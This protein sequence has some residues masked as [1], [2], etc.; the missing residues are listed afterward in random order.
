MNEINETKSTGAAQ[1]AERIEALEASGFNLETYPTEVVEPIE[2]D[3]AEQGDEGDQEIQVKLTLEQIVDQIVD[4][5]K[6]SEWT[7]YQI[8]KALNKVLE[9]VDI[10][11]RDNN[12]EL[13]AYRVRPQMIYNYNKNAMVARNAAGKGIKL[14]GNATTAQTTEFIK[15]FVA[16]QLAK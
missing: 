15:R 4:A 1:V 16:R 3:E 9:V 14:T 8:H 6:L 5:M 12:G 11:V 7:M 2:L 13:I 10:K